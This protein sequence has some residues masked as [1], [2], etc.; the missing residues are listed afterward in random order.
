[1]LLILNNS[2]EEISIFL[3]G[4]LGKK[5]HLHQAGRLIATDLID[6]GNSGHQRAA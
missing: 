4:L 2:Q 3:I 6:G 5:L 1:M